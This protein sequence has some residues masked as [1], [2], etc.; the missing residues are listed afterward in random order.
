MRRCCASTRAERTDLASAEARRRQP[1]RSGTPRGQR[2]QH[3]TSRSCGLAAGPARSWPGPAGAARSITDLARARWSPV[4]NSV[5]ADGPPATVGPSRST[6]GTR[7]AATTG[8]PLAMAS[9]TTRPK[10]SR[11]RCGATKTSAEP[12]RSIFSASVTRPRPVHPAG[13]ARPPR[14]A[15]TTSS[16][17]TAWRIAGNAASRTSRPLRG[18]SA[19]P[20]KTSRRRPE[21]VFRRGVLAKSANRKPLGMTTAS[22]PRCRT[23]TSR[24]VSDTAIDASSFSVTGRSTPPA[25]DIDLDLGVA[26]WKVATTGCS[27]AHSASSAMLG[28]T[29]SWTCTR[30]KRWRRSQ[31]R[32]RAAL[33]GSEVDPG[34]RTVVPQ[35][36]RRTGVAEPAVQ[37]CA[38]R[39]T[40]ARPGPARTLHGPVRPD[41]GRGRGRGSGRHPAP[42]RSTG[43]PGRPGARRC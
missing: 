13:S 27:A 35:R 5:P 10:L 20:R 31:R 28:V 3:S 15:I 14:P 21:P 9:R 43:R 34:D 42:P 24:A 4:G 33:S 6:K 25:R 7:S 8:A 41:A 12:S 39:R 17:G 23:T 38:A 40:A 22:R 32:T 37:R 26:V 36:H 2:H 29:G 16:P 30:S 11:E 18:S 19:R 1:P